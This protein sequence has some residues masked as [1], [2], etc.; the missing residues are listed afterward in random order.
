MYLLLVQA[1]KMSKLSAKVNTDREKGGV[2]MGVYGG[3]LQAC[4]MVVVA[5]ALAASVLAQVRAE[6]FRKQPIVCTSLRQITICPI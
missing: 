1:Q 3:Y 5:I 2:S 6:A 4:G